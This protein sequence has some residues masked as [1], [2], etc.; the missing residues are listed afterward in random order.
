M[1]SSKAFY[2]FIFMM[3]HPYIRTFVT[4]IELAG[5]HLQVVLAA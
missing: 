3:H 5:Q 2:Q 4:R 1:Y